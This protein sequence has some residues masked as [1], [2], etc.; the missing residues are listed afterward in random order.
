[1]LGLGNWVDNGKSLGCKL[2]SF[3][4]VS[5]LLPPTF[6]LFLPCS[7]LILLDLSLIHLFEL[8]LWNFNFHMYLIQENSFVLYSFAFIFSRFGIVQCFVFLGFLLLLENFGL[9]TPVPVGIK[10]LGVKTPL[11]A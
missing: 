1:M 2:P 10:V 8:F 7:F 5:T 9:A 4:P 6:I 11:R 3:H